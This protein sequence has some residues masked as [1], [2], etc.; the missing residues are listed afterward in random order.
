MYCGK[1]L[2]CIAFFVLCN[3]MANCQPTL[4]DLVGWYENNSVTLSWYCQYNCVKSVTVRRSTDSTINFTD[5]GNVKQTKKGI[6]G[7]TDKHPLQGTN[8]YKVL[9]T[10]NSGLNWTSNTICLKQK[11]SVESK[12]PQNQKPPKTTNTSTNKI[13]LPKSSSN[14]IEKLKPVSNLK[15]DSILPNQPIK[16][17]TYTTQ[18][19]TNSNILKNTNKIEKQ[20]PIN[21][22]KQDSISKSAIMPLKKHNIQL[23]SNKLN[24]HKESNDSALKHTFLYPP[25]GK[26]I[27]MKK[28]NGVLV[29]S[30]KFK[31][32]KN[33]SDTALKL[34][35]NN[36]PHVKTKN[37]KFQD[38]TSTVPDVYIKSQYIYL[39][40]NSKNIRLNL[41]TDYKTVNYS[42]KIFNKSNVLIFLVSHLREPQIIVDKRNFKRK[43]T[44]KF[45]LRRNYIEFERAFITI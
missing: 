8:Y 41:P 28:D 36:T 39:D 3:V 6:Q 22:I 2:F 27:P 25:K 29:D 34:G 45:I 5:I 32:I 40:S 10:F 19:D 18:P 20:Y 14:K 7:F 13:V 37:L 33:S 23:D 26:T 24:Q 4:P 15:R 9:V 16:L 35:T 38:D 1:R 12:K 42:L 21:N 17:R 43:G 30:N 11:N 44:F 31:K